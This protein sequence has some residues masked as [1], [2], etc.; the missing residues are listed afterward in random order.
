[1]MPVPGWGPTSCVGGSELPPKGQGADH[2]MW[3]VL[4]LLYCSPVLLTHRGGVGRR[5][6]ASSYLACPWAQLLA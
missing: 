5:G 4:S 2:S 1:M 6:G 3:L